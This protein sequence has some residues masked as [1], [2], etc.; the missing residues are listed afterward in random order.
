VFLSV[1]LV[2]V[3]LNLF[4][5]MPDP[6]ER[7]RSSSP[8]N[9][10]V[11]SEF[12]PGYHLRT[13]AEEGLPGMVGPRSFTINNMGFRGGKLE[14]PKPADEFRIFMIGGSTTECLY[15]DDSES[16]DA[17]VQ[18][19]L[20]ERSGTSL[21]VRVY[22]AGKSGD[23][24]DDHASMLVH[25]IV[26][27]QPDIISVFAGVNDLTRSIYGYD[28]LHRVQ[29]RGAKALPL[30][31]LLVTEF[32]LPRRAHYLLKRFAPT[33]QEL[34]E[35]I[36]RVSNYAEKVE[37]RKS[38]PVSDEHPELNLEAY[39][40]YLRTIIGVARGHGIDLV[41]MTQPSSWNSQI[42][43]SIGDWHWMSYRFG[44]VY[45]EDFMDEALESYNDVMRAIAEEHSVPVYD[46]AR[47]LP[48]SS[49]YFYDDVHL[50]VGG[51]A[52]AGEGLASFI[53]EKQLVPR[54]R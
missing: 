36:T 40:N 32:Q 35:T 13:E 28:Y 37:L 29:E 27:L 52:T 45:R 48:K 39:A 7:I 11:R 9:Q 16:I 50:N 43:S 25:R 51:A 12:S 41:F 53:L 30:A 4:A 34:Q 31:K 20:T 23:A 5:P 33:E 46:L 49:A 24:I 26:Q 19:Q 1:L 14:Q 21:A 2:E 8:P 3:A 42:D 6:Y 15:L 22:N 47:S 54:R 10:Y 18:D 38:V 44:V 17:I